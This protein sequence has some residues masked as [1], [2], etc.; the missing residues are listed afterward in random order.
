M[1]NRDCFNCKESDCTE[2]DVTFDEYLEIK[3]RDKKEK[4]ISDKYKWNKAHPEVIKKA[5]KKH[6]ESHLESERAKS[7]EYYHRNRE[8]ILERNKTDYMRDYKR[9]YM[10]K[11]RHAASETEN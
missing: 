7:R 8:R 2:E 3:G 11:V 9:K 1:C 6:R 4:I 5:R 10:W